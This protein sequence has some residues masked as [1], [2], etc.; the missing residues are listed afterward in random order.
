MACH[1]RTSMGCCPRIRLQSSRRW[2]AR[3][4]EGQRTRETEAREDPTDSDQPV[5]SHPSTFD[6]DKQW[7]LKVRKD[8]TGPS[9]PQTARVARHTRQRQNRKAIHRCDSMPQPTSSQVPEAASDTA[10]H[11]ATMRR[12]PPSPPCPPPS[13]H[14]RS[15]LSTLPTPVPVDRKKIPNQQSGCAQGT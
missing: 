12:P 11:H 3:G 9:Q 13:H 15:F 5:Q 7:G 2:D 4:R 14:L 6:G 8:Q 10:P 1:P